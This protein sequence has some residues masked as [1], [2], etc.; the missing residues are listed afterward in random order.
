MRTATI[1]PH[2]AVEDTY[3][4]SES[5]RPVRLAALP[6]VLFV[7]TALAETAAVALSWGLEPWTDTAI[8]GVYSPALAA[9][10]LL[11]A[12]RHPRSPIGWLMLWL[13]GS[14]AVFADLAQG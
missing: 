14:N 10:G 1:A 11:V 3:V 4:V 8:Y 7:V 5:V 12:S 13:G 2:L 6:L 9:A